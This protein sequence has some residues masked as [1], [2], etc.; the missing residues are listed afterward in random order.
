MRYYGSYTKRSAAGG[1]R[2][3]FG[4]VVGNFLVRD[5][6]L[7]EMPREAQRSQ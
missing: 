1:R 7:K 4:K 6:T 3:E 5:I 2:A